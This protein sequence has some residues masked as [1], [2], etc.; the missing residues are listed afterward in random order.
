MQRS[1]WVH[2]LCVCTSACFILAYLQCDSEVHLLIKRS[3]SFSGALTI[4]HGRAFMAARHGMA[5]VYRDSMGN[6]SNIRQNGAV[7]GIILACRVSKRLFNHS[8]TGRANICNSIDFYGKLS[9]PEIVVANI[10]QRVVTSTECSWTVEFPLINTPGRYEMYVATSWINDGRRKPPR[11]AELNTGNTMHIG[12][13]GIFSYFAA[14]DSW[15]QYSFDGLLMG[16]IERGISNIRDI[17]LM[18]N[19]TRLSFPDLMTLRNMG[20]NE[21]NTVLVQEVFLRHSFPLGPTL[22]RVAL[23]ASSSPFPMAIPKKPIISPDFRIILTNLASQVFF[24][25]GDVSW[26]QSLVINSS[27][28]ITIKHTNK[29]NNNKNHHNNNKLL[30]TSS[31]SILPTR[32]CRGNE[33]GRWM[34]ESACDRYTQNWF[35]LERH[36]GVWPEPG[37]ECSHTTVH[38]VYPHTWSR[39][40]KRNMVWRPHGC[41]LAHYSKC[42]GHSM[43]TC[44]QKQR[45]G[46]RQRS[47]Y[48]S[49][50]HC[51]SSK[52]ILFIAGFGDSLG[53]EQMDNMETLLGVREDDVGAAGRRGVACQGK[54]GYQDHFIWHPHIVIECIERSLE[55]YLNA[56][57]SIDRNNV[58]GTIVLASNLATHHALEKGH[59]LMVR[60][61]KALVAAHQNL[62]QRLRRMNIVYRRIFITGVHIHGFR[63]HIWMSPGRIS[64]FNKLA[65]SILE[66]QGWEVLDVYDLTAARPD[67]TRDGL[68][69]KGGVSWAITDVMMTKICHG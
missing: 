51:L 9:G 4:P 10:S 7:S 58:N 25:E 69:F 22:P 33:T 36:G 28:V 29:N 16:Q 43:T 12:G 55:K 35:D 67:S 30:H 46:H 24:F 13:M 39:K 48:I 38:P 40:H 66:K 3:L 2:V 50:Q 32:L 34:R 56:H 59:G 17:Y 37:S 53:R 42:N 20:Y 44:P 11:W 60:H 8:T 62:T 19:S 1:I 21:N 41:E 27:R 54:T 31:L 47:T 14:N 26:R 52:N 45:Q 15:K 18:S 23:P 6:I 64:M 5:F 65:Q 63:N 57:K 61:L 68:H 49:A